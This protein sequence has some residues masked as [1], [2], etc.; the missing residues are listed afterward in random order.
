MN[1][2][3]AIGFINSFTKLG[4]KVR[5][6]SRI[7][8]L[9]KKLSDPHKELK[10]VHIAGTN[11][12]GSVLEY[13][14]QSLINSG[15]KTG[16]FTSP[17]IRCYEDRIR[18]NSENISHDDVA[19]LCTQVAE[20][21]GDDEYSQFEITM[22][23]AMLY[24]AREKC[25]IVF[26][27]TGIGGTYDCTNIIESPLVSVITSISVDHTALLGNTIEEIAMQKAGIIK[28][29][30]PVVV[31]WNNQDIM[32]IINKE[33]VLKNSKLI[34]PSSI[35]FEDIETNIDGGKF[36][37][38][39]KEYTLKMHG[40]HQI[41]NAA[42]AI[43]TLEVLRTQGFDISDENI[44]KAFGEVQV[45]SRVEVIKGETDIIIDGGHN[46]AGINALLSTLMSMEIKKA[47]FIF[48]MVDTKD[49][50]TSAKMVSTFAKAVVCVDGFTAG[51]I[52]KEK[53]AGY[54]DCEKYAAG[55]DEAFVLASIA[56][57]KHEAA[58]VICGSL[59]MTEH[60]RKQIESKMKK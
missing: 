4:G 34:V 22:A 32:S 46:P 30:R 45:L 3:E 42:T 59:Y 60:F 35:E 24:F 53:L 18:I 1:Y 33:C 31:S 28:K 11:G 44:I 6:L 39:E 7:E 21:A 49:V 50:E 20:A 9:M 43:K 19:M 8:K 29:D 36:T 55:I 37:Y 57:R 27:E 41:V 40:R 58:I 2:E 15:Y 5:D 23:I 13:I 10:V 38:K 51:A 54:F 26:L 16:Q 17:F 25:D 48:G 14:S 12:K 47:V 56:A 52:P